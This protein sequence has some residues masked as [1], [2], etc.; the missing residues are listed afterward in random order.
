MDMKKKVAAL[1]GTGVAV[2]FLALASMTSIPIIQGEGTDV[3][4]DVRPP[5]GVRS[6]T[7]RPSLPP[8]SYLPPAPIEQPISGQ[9]PAAAELPAAGTGGARDESGGWQTW[10]LLA[11]MGGALVASGGLASLRFHKR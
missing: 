10:M 6:D 5:I 11:I 1:L 7:S 9:A 8:A 4:T 3:G 2:A